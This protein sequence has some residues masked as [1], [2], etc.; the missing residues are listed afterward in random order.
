MTSKES[1]R[2][3]AIRNRDKLAAY[4][5]KYNQLPESKEKIKLSSKKYYESHKDYFKNR[6]Q[7]KKLKLQKL[8]VRSIV[9]S[10]EFK[11]KMQ[12]VMK[13]YRKSHPEVSIKI[14]ESLKGKPKSEEHRKKIQLNR[15]R[16]IIPKKDTTIEIKTQNF[17]KQMGIEFYTH[18]W[19]GRIEHSYQCDILIPSM[20]LV[21]ECEGDYWHKYPIG[22]DID[23]IRT[24]ELIQ[25][26]FKVLRLWEHEIR[27]MNLNSFENKLKE[28]VKW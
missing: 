8:G 18:F 28:V 5:K 21:I 26:G 20:N 22:N 4:S 17:L 3:W 2:Q 16:M 12:N 9:G 15:N 23:K 25:K 10:P 27:E 6:E 1:K 7:Q 11:L 24:S 14:S 19:I 13:E